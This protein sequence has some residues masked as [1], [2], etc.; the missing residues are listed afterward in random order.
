MRYAAR[1]HRAANKLKSVIT[2]D[3][4]TLAELLRA[5]PVA[6]SV[7]D[8]RVAERARIAEYRD[9][10]APTMGDIWILKVL[11]DRL[12]LNSAVAKDAE[13]ARGRGEDPLAV[14][15]VARLDQLFDKWCPPSALERALGRKAT[16]ASR[17][18]KASPKP[19]P[20]RAPSS[21]RLQGES[22]SSIR[23]SF[24]Q[25]AARMLGVRLTIGSILSYR[26][27]EHLRRVRS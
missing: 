13:S 6:E 22:R 5:P 19:K 18:R 27:K 24:V 14:T 3:V 15:V 16:S 23:A 20:R 10:I 12:L 4:T 25:E 11:L 21:G 7:A 26:K 9:G 8:W 17:P 2:Q 1:V